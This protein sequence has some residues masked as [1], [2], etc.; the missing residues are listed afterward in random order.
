MFLRLNVVAEFC[1][2]VV[3]PSMFKLP[4]LNYNT[5]IKVK[6]DRTLTLVQIAVVVNFYFQLNFSFPLFF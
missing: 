2:V 1:K 4:Q 5:L 3:G 6:N